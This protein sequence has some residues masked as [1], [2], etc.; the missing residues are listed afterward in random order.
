MWILLLESKYSVKNYTV[1]F[2]INLYLYFPFLAY[3]N[4]LKY[5]KST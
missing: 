1:I 4:W 5:V 2:I 3:V